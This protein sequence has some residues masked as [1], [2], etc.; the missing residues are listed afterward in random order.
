[1]LL[2]LLLLLMPSPPSPL[3][4]SLSRLVSVM[5]PSDSWVAKWCHVAKLKPGCYAVSM[6][7]VLPDHVVDHLLQDHGI[8]YTPREARTA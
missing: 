8:R 6:T 2:L 3:P 7:G 4:L 1:M 5:N